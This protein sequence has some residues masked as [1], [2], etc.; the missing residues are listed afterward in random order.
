MKP[1][2][3]MHVHGH[4]FR[5]GHDLSP[6]HPTHYP[7]LDFQDL[8]LTREADLSRSGLPF[9]LHEQAFFAGIG[10]D[11]A[12]PAHLTS[13]EQNDLEDISLVPLRRSCGSADRSPMNF[14]HPT[15]FTRKTARL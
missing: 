9:T 10:G 5:V 3:P 2:T 15:E 12:G 7:L 13:A 11:V 6:T 4:R 14:A 1:M 8:C